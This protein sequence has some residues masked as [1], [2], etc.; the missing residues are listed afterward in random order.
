[1]CLSRIKKLF[2]EKR[3][4]LEKIEPKRGIDGR[5][6]N[7][8]NEHFI[9]HG[10]MYYILGRVAYYRFLGL[11]STSPILFHHAIEYFLK[12]ALSN[13][14]S[15]EDLKKK[16]HN[17]PSLLELYEEKFPESKVIE[18]IE[19]IKNFHKM[20][21]T[22]YVQPNGSHRVSHSFAP[23]KNDR[24]VCYQINGNKKRLIKFDVDWRVEEIDEVIFNICG[25][26]KIG[27]TSI[28]DY[29]RFMAEDSSEFTENNKYFKERNVTKL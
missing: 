16:K 26:I 17:L 3:I 21:R 9:T 2:R 18:N 5:F 10:A 28:Y 4:E 29:I 19:F 13:L 25:D 24:N 11:R 27:P 7:F 12:A 23:T 14:Y 8:S 1:M 22:R 20:Y 15:L 6:K